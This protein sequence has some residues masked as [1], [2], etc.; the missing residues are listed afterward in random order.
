MNVKTRIK[1]FKNQVRNSNTKDNSSCFIGQ[2]AFSEKT[3]S[4]T[5]DDRRSKPTRR[6]WKS[7]F[8]QKI[9]RKRRLILP[10]FNGNYRGIALVLAFWAKNKASQYRL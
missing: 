4:N 1:Y 2:N 6:A 10:L 8:G 7:T 5:K 3:K 9:R